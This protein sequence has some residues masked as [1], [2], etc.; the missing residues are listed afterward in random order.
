MLPSHKRR[1]GHRQS[2]K[3]K[4]EKKESRRHAE[5]SVD[6][7]RAVKESVR[8]QTQKKKGN[9]LRGAA[10]SLTPG[11]GKIA[12]GGGYQK[13]LAAKPRTK[14]VRGTGGFSKKKKIKKKIK[15]PGRA[16]RRRK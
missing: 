5:K 8:S 6:V 1:F 7:P 16:I 15:R 9:L 4:G 10:P 2:T 12:Q 11:K 3:H 13:K 14:L